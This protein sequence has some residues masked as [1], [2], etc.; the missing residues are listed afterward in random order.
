MFLNYPLHNAIEL[1]KISGSTLRLVSALVLVAVAASAGAQTR[2]D[3]EFDEKSK[4]WQEIAVQLPPLPRAENLA[5]FFVSATASQVFAIDLA[6]VSVGADAVVRYTMV[7]TS[8]EGAKNISYEGIRC[9]SREKKLYAFGHDDGTWSRSRRDQ[10][11]KMLQNA[12]NRQH[13]ALSQDFICQG[14]MVV[15]KVADI[16]GRLRNKRPFATESD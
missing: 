1:R 9:Q 12:A 5:P 6:S 2:F 8:A 16:V 10:W 15:G 7:T 4:P 11:E 13:A 3:E 14:G